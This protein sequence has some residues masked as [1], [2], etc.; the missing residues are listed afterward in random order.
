MD[1]P[2]HPGTLL[3]SKPEMKLLVLA[4]IPPPVHGQSVMVQALVTALQQ[5][6]WSTVAPAEQRMLDVEV[7]VPTFDHDDPTAN[8]PGEVDPVIAAEAAAAEAQ[9]EHQL[10]GNDMMRRGGWS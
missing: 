9:N 2:H 6:P 10:H 3:I 1:A 7:G 4:Q 8:L 5:E